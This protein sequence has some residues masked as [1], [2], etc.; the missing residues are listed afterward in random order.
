MNLKDIGDNM[1]NDFLGID[2]Q[3]M[4]WKRL[5]ALYPLPRTSYSQLNTF[6]NC[7][8]EF[9]LAYMQ[10]FQERTGNKY[11]ELGSLLHEIFERQGKQLMSEN[12][13][14]KSEAI[15]MFN[16]LFFRID[17]KHYIDIEDRTKMYQKGI[18]AIEGYYSVYSSI[19]PLFLEKEFLEEVGEGIPPVKSFVDR[20]EG[21][22]EDPSTWVITDY[23][24]GS[25]PK[26]KE[27]LRGDIQLGLYVAQVFKRYGA[28]P[29]AVQFYHPV[30][31]KFQT[32]VHIGEG[33]YEFTG[34]R[35]PVVTFSVADV[36][37]EARRIVSEIAKCVETGVW[38][39]KIEAW[40]CKNCFKFEECQPFNKT[41]QGWANI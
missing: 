34:Q 18:T 7:P 32:A 22:P 28:Y 6:K 40:S 26:T 9:F 2:K 15:K 30:P 23:K 19:T 14:L 41:Q 12:P 16:K 37:I 13:F 5:K 21:D 35:K 31:N 24:T 8:Y 10:G 3:R 38:E 29:K 20:I 36:L 11:T 17:N 1:L 39:K 4:E 27:Y 33:V 25:Q